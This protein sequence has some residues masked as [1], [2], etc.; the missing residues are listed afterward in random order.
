[1][2]KIDQEVEKIETKYN[3]SEAQNLAPVAYDQIS[4]NRLVKKLWE[5]NVCEQGSI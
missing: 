4:S 2:E 1:M 5:E 3:Y